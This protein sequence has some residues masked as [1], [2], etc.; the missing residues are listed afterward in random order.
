MDEKFDKYDS[1][2]KIRRGRLAA[3]DTDSLERIEHAT[4]KVLEEVGLRFEGDLET[5]D[6]WRQHGMII[7]EDRV[8]LDGS[9]LRSVIRKTAPASFKLRARNPLYDTG[10][11]AEEP[12]VFAPVYGPPNIQFA[13]GRRSMGT[14]ADYRQLVALAH[15]SPSLS[16]TGHM[17][18]VIDDIPESSR[19]IHMA[20][21]HLECSDKPFMGS[22]ASPDATQTVIDMT[23]LTVGR[24]PHDGECELL[25]LINSTP[26]LTYKEN[27]LKCLRTVAKNHQGL[28]VTS[29]MMMGATSPVT[30]AGTL[31]QGYAEALAGLALSQLW[32]PGTPVIFGLHAIPFSMRTMLPVFGDPVSQLVQ[33]YSVQLARRLGIPA[34]GDGGVTS[35]NVDDAQAGYEASRATVASVTSGADFILHAAGWLEQGRCISFSKFE[36]EQ[37]A[38]SKM[39]RGEIQPFPPPIPLDAEILAAL[40]QSAKL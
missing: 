16:N 27:P 5:L 20:L 15:R 17:I 38:I 30:V 18:C 36:R 3:F 14:L 32:S 23:N 8:F 19:P 12:Q 11:G 13:D 31:I 26:P 4:D 29:Y 6:I 28:M 33:F 10:I 25:H 35:S 9:W 39:H 22:V 37:Q 34:R 40:Y 1:S 24:E 7:K 2:E 21:A